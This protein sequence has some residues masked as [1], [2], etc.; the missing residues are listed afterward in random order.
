ML[1]NLSRRFVEKK[2]WLAI[3]LPVWVL[4]GF[5]CSQLAVFALTQGLLALNVPLG[6][7]NQ[8]VLN[9]SAGIVVYGVTLLLVIGLPW[10]LKGYKT[11]RE[12]LGLQRMPEWLDVALAPAGFLVYIVLSAVLLY[13]A[14]ML[15]F[16]PLDDVQ[17][18]GFNGISQRYEFL[19]AFFTLVILAPLAEEVLF[20]GYL[21]GKLRQHA[22]VWLAILITSVLFGIAHMAWNVGIDVFALSIILCLVRVL[23]RSLWP[24][25]LLHS[26]KNFVA[27]YL[28]FINPSLLGILGA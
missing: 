5:V 16:I 20:R 17:N 21:F 19:L 11:T 23:T 4:V 6:S 12:E 15:P 10:K 25:I 18:T 26:L 3:A 22:P 2:A 27:F 7:I 28:L 14:G 9:A 1:R 24:A 8:A 13:V